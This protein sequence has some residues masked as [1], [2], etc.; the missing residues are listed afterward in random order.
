MLQAQSSLEVFVM[1]RSDSVS[2]Q[3]LV[4]VFAAY[5][6]I[7]VAL[8]SLIGLLGLPMPA[9][10]WSTTA[11]VPT[12]FLMS[13]LERQGRHQLAVLVGLHASAFSGAVLGVHGKEIFCWALNLV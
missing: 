5:A 8:F 7:H 1:T 12:W 6:C 2:R 11:L 4:L 3:P 10:W 13:W 9:L